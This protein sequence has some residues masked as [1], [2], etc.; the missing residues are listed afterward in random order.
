MIL[1]ADRLRRSGGYSQVPP[2]ITTIWASCC[3]FVFFWGYIAFSQY[4]LIWYANIPEETTW[5]LARQTTAGIR[6]SLCSCSVICSSR[7]AD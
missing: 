2:T 5:Y 7:S 1:A 4:M 6:R 3:F